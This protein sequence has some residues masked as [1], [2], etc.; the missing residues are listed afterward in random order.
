MVL[1]LNAYRE[2]EDNKDL[3]EARPV[4]WHLLV[5]RLGWAGNLMEP[6][7]PVAS[8]RVALMTEVML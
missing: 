6:R 3:R 7:Y 8:R 1:P 5:L 2:I 4:E